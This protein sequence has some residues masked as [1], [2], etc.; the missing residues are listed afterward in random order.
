LDTKSEKIVNATWTPNQAKFFLSVNCLDKKTNCKIVRLAQNCQ[1]LREVQS[2][3]GKGNDELSATLRQVIAH[4]IQYPAKFQPLPIPILWRKGNQLNQHVH[5]F[6]LI[7][8]VKSSSQLTFKW[9][10]RQGKGANF[11]QFAAT[12]IGGQCPLKKMQLSWLDLTLLTGEQFGGWV[13]V[14]FIAFLRLMK[15]VFSAA[16]FV[17]PDDIY[18]E[19]DL[20]P[21]NRWLVKELAG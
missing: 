1:S 9:F 2:G 21:S 7:G 5:L 19:P 6:F 3:N 13:A 20:P 16:N 10:K 18:K 17:S 4:S 12:W 8:I 15:W 14:H 11:L